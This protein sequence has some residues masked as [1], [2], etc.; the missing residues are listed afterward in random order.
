MRL[1]KRTITVV[2]VVVACAAGA[3][4]VMGSRAPSASQTEAS[5][6]FFKP[7]QDYKTSGGQQ[8]KPRW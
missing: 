5:R 7:P 3:W 6:N 2:I 8:M 1:S 4:F